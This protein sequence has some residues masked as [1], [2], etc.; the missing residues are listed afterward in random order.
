MI[1]VYPS[2]TKSLTYFSARCYLLKQSSGVVPQS[3]VVHSGK[4]I[5]RISICPNTRSRQA[6]RYEVAQPERAILMSPCLPQVAVDPVE[7]DEVDRES[8]LGRSFEREMRFGVF[9]GMDRSKSRDSN[10]RVGLVVLQESP[11]RI[12]R[13]ANEPQIT[14]R[15]GSDEV[16]LTFVVDDDEDWTGSS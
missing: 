12:S 5:R 13:A 4:D 16:T 9:R 10:V 2:L 6:D 1:V 8:F 3:A 15:T 7:R 11:E 14:S